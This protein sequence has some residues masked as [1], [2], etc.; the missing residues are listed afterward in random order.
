M[1]KGIIGCFGNIVPLKESKTG[2]R[3]SFFIKFVSFYKLRSRLNFKDCTDIHVIMP[4]IV[5][6]QAAYNK[7]DLGEHVRFH[8]FFA[9]RNRREDM[10]K[11]RSKGTKMDINTSCF[12]ITNVMLS[13][14]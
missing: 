1:E 11:S 12:T 14:T 5:E 2:E 4:Y 13:F 8:V 3:P 10:S 6:L 7:F 9:I